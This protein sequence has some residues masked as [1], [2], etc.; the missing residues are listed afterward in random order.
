M[1]TILAIF[2]LSLTAT[3]NAQHKLEKIWETDTV[4]AVPESV[5]PADNILYVSLIDGGGWDA[6]G[7]GGVAKLGL[8]GKVINASWITGLNAPKGIAKVGNRL[9]V[10]DISEVVVINIKE[11]KIEKKIKIE[12]GQGLNDVT[13]SDKG[14]VYV[15]DSKTARVW[16]IANDIP[17][18]YL[19]NM[20]GVN[21]L[22]AVKDELYIASGK[23][24][25]KAGPDKKIT[26][27][28][29]LPGDGDGIEPI[30]NGDFVATSWPGQVYYVSAKGAV[31]IL[32]DTKADKK[33][34]ADI[35]YDPIKRI[36]YVPTFNAKT[37]VAYTLK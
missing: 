15:S 7:K 1:K 24:F 20:Q 29:E 21:G 13:A 31:E 6:D 4:I 12:G 36:V 27:V 22:R 35:G 5:L 18:L 16:L 11:G 32:L 14:M 10:A 3:A 25:V 28:A 37:I 19:E 2:L 30:G 26:P 17:T 34:T 8:D 33:N 23:S 9:F